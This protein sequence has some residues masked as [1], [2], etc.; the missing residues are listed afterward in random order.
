MI[1]RTLHAYILRELLRVFLLTASALTT[2]MAFG[3]MFRPMTKQGIDVSQVMVILVNLMPAM[4]AYAIPIA[5]LFA[6][7]LVYWRMS[8]DNELT[9]CRAGGISF[10][11]IIMPAFLLGL[12]VATVDL[13]FVNYVVPRFLQSTERIVQRDLASLIVNQIGKNERYERDGL[14]VTADSAEQI[15]SSVPG[16]SIVV[17]Q[18]MAATVN[19][20]EGKPFYAVGQR[21]ELHIRDL[22][23]ED[24]VE[25]DGMIYNAMGFDPSRAFQTASSGFIRLPPDGPYRLPSFFRSKAKFLNWIDLMAISRKP[26]LFPAVAQ[27][28]ERI[29]RVYEYER[30]STNI[31]DWW[32]AQ[33]AEGKSS[34][35]FV[36]PAIGTTGLNE[37]VLFADKAVINDSGPPEE[38]LSFTGSSPDRTIRI[39]QRRDGKMVTAYTCQAADVVL[40]SGSYA[41]NGL[42]A[43][44]RLHGNVYLDLRQQPQLEPKEKDTLSLTGLALDPALKT[45]VYTWNNPRDW[46]LANSRGAV[47]KLGTQYQ[48]EE[49]KL[50]RTISSELHSRGS[51]SI[52]C[53]TLVLLGAALGI[54]MRGQNPLAVFVVGF[55]PAI[56][57]VLLITAGRQMTE[58]GARNVTVGII[59]IWAGNA[60]LLAVVAGVY[61]KLLRR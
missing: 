44:L 51:F 58:G 4:L 5:A 39:E 55:V 43:S 6:A 16:E 36:Q 60:V 22:P 45:V 57:L 27:I 31:R 14:S 28:V 3:G 1:Y 8:T 17:L 50:L 11:A 23:S 61:L 13:M 9:A 7:V 2:L 35:A 24:A 20:G 46:A 40:S 52:S 47:Q 15:P 59:L 18:G 25:I 10:V 30:I 54:L 49:S 34:V 48:T 12:A 56:I 42:T 38:A 19:N 53:L 37:I 33:R 26:Y 21:A 32:A 41:V 29:K